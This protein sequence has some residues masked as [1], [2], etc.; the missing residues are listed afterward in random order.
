MFLPQIV[1]RARRFAPTFE[2][3]GRETVLPK[4]VVPGEQLSEF[5]IKC[6]GIGVG[7]PVGSQWRIGDP[8]GRFERN[9]DAS[10]TYD[11]NSNRARLAGDG[12][13][14]QTLSDHAQRTVVEIA[15]RRLGQQSHKFDPVFLG[16]VLVLALEFPLPLLLV[17]LVHF[18]QLQVEVLQ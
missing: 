1:Q 10:M 18:P 4:S 8:V 13:G 12:T 11:P 16:E 15:F 17:L 2:R 7:E 6:V 14:L 3:H 9:D 5:T